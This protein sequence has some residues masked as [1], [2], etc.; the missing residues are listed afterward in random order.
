MANSRVLRALTRAN[1]SLPT[2]GL[3]MVTTL[4][5]AAGHCSAAHTPHSVACTQCFSVRSYACRHWLEHTP[6]KVKP[7]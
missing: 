7:E 1:A 2:A 5:S 6:F 4:T 3:P